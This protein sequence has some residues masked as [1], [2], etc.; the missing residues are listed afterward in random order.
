MRGSAAASIRSKLVWMTMA[1]SLVAVLVVTLFSAWFGYQSRRE[2]LQQ[3]LTAVAGILAANV[4][5]PLLFG[6]RRAAR[7]TL[8]ALSSRPVV[9]YARLLD[10]GGEVFASH[11]SVDP[12]LA[13]PAEGIRV[14]GEHALLSKR[15]ERGQRFLG[16]L[17]LGTTLSGLEAAVRETL[18][19]S[20]AVMAAAAV[21]AWLLARLLGQAISR[22]IEHL[23][24]TMQAVSRNRDF[25]RRAVRGSDDEVGTLIDGF[26]EMIGTIE[27][28]NRE[29]AD[30]RDRAERANRSKTRFLATMSHELRTPL[31]AIIGFSEIISR[32]VLGE[33][34]ERYRSYGSDI[35][36][37]AQYLMN[38]IDDLLDMS[39]L[40]SGGYSINEEDVAVAGLLAECAAMVQPQA[41]AKRVSLATQVDGAEVVLRADDRG[42]RQVVLNLVGNAIKF[43]PSG[44]HVEI[45]GGFGAD[46]RYVIVVA[47]DGPGIPREDLE[48]VLE[49]FEQVRSHLSREHGGTGLGLAISRAIVQAHGGRLVLESDRG[50]GTTA[51]VEFPA[52]RVVVPVPAA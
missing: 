13:W 9:T 47:D 11:G 20:A 39:R 12:G 48:R 22:P 29:L 41:Q 18:V 19:I 4:E 26:N 38:L 45:T 31:N 17:Q 8:S 30:A 52:D 28:Y 6:D 34:P 32:S 10:D 36:R 40:D 46:G 35:H 2:A 24:A 33:L 16:T 5:A 43:T 50:S 7:E 42:L 37:S 49:P 14:A 51:R 3:E 44:G 1:I 21:V 27:R 23:A 25:G 15:I